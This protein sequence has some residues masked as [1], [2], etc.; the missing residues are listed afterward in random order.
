MEQI[1]ASFITNYPTECTILALWA[2][3][4]TLITWLILSAR[5]QYKA[6]KADKTDVCEWCQ[7]VHTR[8]CDFI[9][10]DNSV[11]N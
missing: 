2:I 3:G 10:I 8:D 9:N 6:R 5:K 11:E 7:K 1:A 4:L